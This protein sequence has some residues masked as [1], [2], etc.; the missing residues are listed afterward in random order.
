MAWITPNDVEAVYPF[1]D[2]LTQPQCDHIQGLCES[3]VGFQEEP[4]SPKLKAVV[5]DI[6]VR[7]WRGV[8]SA[9]TNPAGFES[10][11]IDDYS[12]KHP[13]AGPILTGFGLMKSEKAALR[14]AI[15]IPTFSVVRLSRGPLETAGIDNLPDDDEHC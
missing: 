10:E 12:Y 1:A 15:G 5:T 14:R 2:D 11:Q 9:A 4:V 8:Q 7:W 3:V 13:A 6:A